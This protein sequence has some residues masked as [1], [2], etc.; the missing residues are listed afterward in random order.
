MFVPADDPTVVALTSAVRSGDV[1]RLS[2]LLAEHP[3]LATARFG[4]S[5]GMSREALHVAT[6]W[7]GHFPGVAATIDVMIDAGA[8]VNARFAGPH[9]ETPLHWAASSDDVDALDALLDAGADIEADGG[10]LTGGPPLDDAVI[11]GQ[12]NA[13]RRLIERGATSKL[14]H[15]AA[16]GDAA[17]VA[18]LLAPRPNQDVISSALWHACNGGQLETALL[19]LEAGGDPLWAG[20]DDRSPLQAARGSDNEELAAVMAAW[21]A[22]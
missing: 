15:A 8:N 17:R 5:D 3:H 4:D 21:A 22:G 14:F 2:E 13:A 1:R 19:L 11:F 18:E 12:W 16:L 6:D 7:P 10:V 20:Y 9:V